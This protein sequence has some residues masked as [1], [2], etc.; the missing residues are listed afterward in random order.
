MERFFRNPQTIRMSVNSVQKPLAR[1][2]STA[3]ST[4][5]RIQPLVVV[6]PLDCE[7]YY[8]HQSKAISQ[9][10]SAASACRHWLCYLSEGLSRIAVSEWGN[11][12]TDQH[13]SAP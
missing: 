13:R 6:P 5:G 12:C 7:G 1:M 10:E 11:G 2:R 3:S 9:I 8:S 4:G